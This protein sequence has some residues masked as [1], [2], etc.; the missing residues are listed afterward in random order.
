MRMMNKHVLALAAAGAVT[1]GATAASAQYYE[2]NITNSVRE[3]GAEAE[4][5]LRSDVRAHNAARVRT[6]GHVRAWQNDPGP[7][8]LPGAAIG[9]AGAVAGAAV[10]GA[11]N[12]AGVA[13]GAPVYGPYAYDNP[14]YGAFAY[15]NS[16]GANAPANFAYRDSQRTPGFNAPAGA[17]QGQHYETPIGYGSIF[18]SPQQ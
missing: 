10:T 15:D 4:T 16:Y 13:V 7:F 3:Y 9:A 11:A 1:L 17:A 5:G 8:A 18:T 6:R 12:V 2:P 14:A